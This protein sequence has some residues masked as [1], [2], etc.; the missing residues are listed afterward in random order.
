MTKL[1]RL[2]IVPQKS[3]VTDLDP[4]GQMNDVQKQGKDIMLESLWLANVSRAVLA[5]GPACL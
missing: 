5:G 3:W 2:L 1:T 4:L